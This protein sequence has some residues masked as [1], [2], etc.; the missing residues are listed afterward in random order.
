MV[1]KKKIKSWIVSSDYNSHRIDYWLK[2]NISFVTYPTLCKLLRK[3]IVRVN[4]K[5]AKNNTV[6]RI[7]D[8]INFTRIIQQEPSFDRKEKYNSKFEEFIKKLVVYKDKFKIILNKP[9]GLAVQGGTN[10]KLNVDI[11]LDSLKFNLD[12]R[13]KLVHRI[14]KQTSGLLMVARSLNS[15]RYYGE[16]FKKRKI[17]K[18]YLAIVHGKL[19]HKDG[20][21]RFQNWKGKKFVIINFV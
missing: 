8:K 7:G 19:K 13:P 18:V 9:A 3:G 20:K 16:L 15:S 10:I 12:E 14:D 17:E 1:I 11:M 2:K 21:N 5:R 4:G 6:L